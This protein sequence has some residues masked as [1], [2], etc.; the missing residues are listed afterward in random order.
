MIDDWVNGG[1][2][3][4]LRAV[5]DSEQGDL[6][7]FVSLADALS[8]PLRG[9]GDGRARIELRIGG[10]PLSVSPPGACPRCTWPSHGATARGASRLPVGHP[11]A[12]VRSRVLG[13]SGVAVD[14]VMG[15]EVPGSVDAPHVAA[16]PAAGVGQQVEMAPRSPCPDPSV[17]VAAVVDVPAAGAHR[18]HRPNR[19]P[20]DHREDL[21]LYVD[22]HPIRI[23]GPPRDGGE[24]APRAPQS[25]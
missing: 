3:A 20:F 1:A 2:P 13:H 5:A 18:D 14:G 12:A 24:V 21:A 10:R 6:R 19:A 15:G 9:V 23:A 16:C 25:S 11:N 7:D 4:R 22:L 8:G 17:H